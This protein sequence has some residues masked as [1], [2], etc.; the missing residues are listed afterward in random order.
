M[1]LRGR[2]EVEQVLHA[3]GELFRAEGLGEVVECTEIE[4]EMARVG[5]RPSGENDDGDGGC[6]GVAAEDFAYAKAV[7]VRQHEIEQDEIGPVPSDNFERFASA[8]CGEHIMA[9]LREMKAHQVG[10]IGF[11]I[12]TENKSSHVTS[13]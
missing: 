1:G 2:A 3:C 6:A 12:N 13:I 9:G 11:V 5:C 8:R 4:A 7:D 10:H